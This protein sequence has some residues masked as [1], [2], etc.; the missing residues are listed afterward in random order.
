[1]WK[2]LKSVKIRVM[3]GML[4]MF[5]HRYSLNTWMEKSMEDTM[6]CN[7]SSRMLILKTSKSSET[8][9]L[10]PVITC[11]TKVKRFHGETKFLIPQYQST[12][13]SFS[14]MSTNKTVF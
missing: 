8:I 7:M 10:S 13:I 2:H 5:M 3:P 1:M 11:I 6:L 4:I 12:M 14:K 9:M